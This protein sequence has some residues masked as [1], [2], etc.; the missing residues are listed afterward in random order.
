MEQL[1]NVPQTKGYAEGWTVKGNMN[2]LNTYKTT[3][4]ARKRKG[5]KENKNHNSRNN[6]NN[7]NSKNNKSKSRKSKNNNKKNKNLN[8]ARKSARNNMR[9]GASDWMSSQYSQG[10]INNPEHT[11]GMF[12]HSLSATRG[13]LNMPPNLGSAGSGGALG[14]L[15]G[16]NVM[17]V[18][19]P[20]V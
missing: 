10:P 2:S 9:G 3:G 8:N 6:R 11:T 17:H 20:L 14:A 16:A 5:K 15:E 19:A 18:G 13:D 7:R 4:G 1:N 12:S